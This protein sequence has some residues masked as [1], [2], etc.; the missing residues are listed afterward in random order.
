[1][2]TYKEGEGQT[3]NQYIIDIR[4]TKVKTLLLSKS[5]THTDLDVGFNNPNYFA[6][7][8]KKYTGVT[9]LKFQYDAKVTP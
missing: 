8:F 9:P 6:T 5:V 2:R 4:I 7:I 3:I 1:M